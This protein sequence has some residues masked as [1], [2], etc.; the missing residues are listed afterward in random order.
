MRVLRFFIG[1]F[2]FHDRGLLSKLGSPFG[3]ECFQI[4]KNILVGFLHGEL[5]EALLA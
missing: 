2:I 1:G 3:T 5:V 4:I